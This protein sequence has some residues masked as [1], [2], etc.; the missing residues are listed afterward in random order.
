MAPITLDV[1]VDGLRRLRFIRVR[2]S[3]RGMYRGAIGRCLV[4]K[5]QAPLFLEPEVVVH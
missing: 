4:E 3:L 1:G 5:P 2:R